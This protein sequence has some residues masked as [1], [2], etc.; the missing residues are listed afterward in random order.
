MTFKKSILL[1][2][3]LALHLVG[4]AQS[5]HWT[6]KPNYTSITRFSSNLFRVKTYNTMGIWD[7]EG[8]T[9]VPLTMDSITYLTNGYAL[10]MS[11]NKGKYRILYVIK[12]N[13]VRE[14]VK[15]EVYASESPFFSEDRCL[16]ANKKGK[17]GYMDP[18]G[19][20]VIPC[21]FTAAYPFQSG[22]ASVSKSKGGGELFAIDKGGNRVADSG[23]FNTGTDKQM[24]TPYV[25]TPDPS[26]LRFM[27]NKL[28]GYKKDGVT[29]LPPQF[30]EAENVE[31]DYAIVMVDHLYGVIK[32]NSATVD[33]SVSESGGKLRANADIPS[34]WDT[35][36][37]SII[38]IV[39]DASKKSFEMTGTETHRTLE[40]SVSNETGKKVYDLVCEKLVLWRSFTKVDTPK[41]P[42]AGHGQSS[43]SGGISVSAPA[44]V[45]ANAKGV[46]S[47][48]IRVVNRGNTARSIS[49]SLST[50][51]K[52]S[53]QLAAGKSGSVTVTVPVT[54]E[55]KC[56]ITASGGGV[57]SSCSTTLKPAF[58]L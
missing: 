33:C 37:A 10:A 16:V 36:T 20:V 13:G 12:E 11:K 47:V 42:D 31:E 38:R 41:K 18:S 6:I 55:T 39:N 5:A 53:I 19:K 44:S 7:G 26:Y 34:V 4:Q 45:K 58:V 48:S 28:Y 50:G 57:S 1:L 30:E 43:S 22:T 56:K 23:N 8:K 54:K 21:N 3:C 49:I 51:Q 14:A 27:E 32:F 2:V 17:L 35:K 29:V 15:D 24:C 25:V 52:S 9:V 40:A 46:C